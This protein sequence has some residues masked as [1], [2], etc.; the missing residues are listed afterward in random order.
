[1]GV[2]QRPS[3]ALE[4]QPGA[5]PDDSAFW[6]LKFQDG[7]HFLGSL[8]GPHR[9]HSEAFSKVAESGVQ[10]ERN[11]HFLPLSFLWTAATSFVYILSVVLLKRL[12]SSKVF[13]VSFSPIRAF[14]LSLS[15]SQCL[16]PPLSLPPSLSFSLSA[17]F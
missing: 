6:M 4:S 10:G 12:G 2:S 17:S 11:T 5:Q 15:V 8:L 7:L 16:S 13:A 14:S 9:S 3:S 1:M